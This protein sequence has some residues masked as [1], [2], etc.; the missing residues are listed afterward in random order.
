MRI[1]LASTFKQTHRSRTL[2][3]RRIDSWVSGL[4]MGSSLDPPPTTTL[5]E[6]R[7][8]LTTWN[9]ALSSK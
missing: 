1:V 6:V 9:D 2:A 4:Q 7:D 8:K 3:D 5:V